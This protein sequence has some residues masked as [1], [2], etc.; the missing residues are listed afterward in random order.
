M[1]RDFQSRIED[2]HAW[3]IFAEVS[4]RGAAALWQISDAGRA[5]SSEVLLGR[6]S[7]KETKRI[8]SAVRMSIPSLLLAG[9][10][11]ESLLK[12]ILLRQMYFRGQPMTIV[13]G[14]AF[15][16]GSLKSHDLVGLA[17]RAGVPLDA[18]E[19]RLLERLTT[20]VTWAGRYPVSVGE[21]G[22]VPGA[23]RVWSERWQGCHCPC[24]Q[25]VQVCE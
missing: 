16:V 23:R 17:E 5:I 20:I 11:F 15:L 22:L 18:E 13:K 24:G 3:F 8:G 6:A 19:T 10:G 9:F 4:F 2:P 12:G 7:L 14:K 25:D 1:A 21:D